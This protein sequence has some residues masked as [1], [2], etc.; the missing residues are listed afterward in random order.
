MEEIS[1]FQSILGTIAIFAYWIIYIA[2]GFASAFY[3]YQ[4]AIKQDQRALNIHPYWWAIFALI[5]S[6][7][8]L[9]A[10]WLMQH[11][12]LGKQQ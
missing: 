5:G 12:S 2:V 3:V 6:V 11:S 10:Y 9:A 4:D 8:A 1:A 7:W